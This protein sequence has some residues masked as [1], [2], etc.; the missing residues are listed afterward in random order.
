MPPPKNF[1]VLIAGGGIGGLTLAIILGAA[2]IDYLILE[3]SSRLQSTGSTIGLNACCLRLLEQ[4]GLL[5]QIMA[6]SKPLG[7]LHLRHEDLSKV[8]HLDFRFGEDHYGYYGHVMCRPDLYE[9][10]KNEVPEEKVLLRK[11]VIDVIEF[12]DDDEEATTISQAS[13]PSREKSVSLKKSQKNGGARRRLHRRSRSNS[14]SST[15]SSTSSNSSSNSNGVGGGGVLVRCKDGSVYRGDILVGADG[16]YSSVRE[17][18]YDRLQRQRKLPAC[19]SEPLNLSY[20]CVLGISKEYDTK[21]I[22]ILGDRFS[23]FELINCPDGR[24]IWLGPLPNNRIAW[25]YGRNL[26]EKDKDDRDQKDKYWN[27]TSPLAQ[28]LQRRVEGVSTVYGVKLGDIIGSTPTEKISSVLLEDKTFQTWHTRRVVLLGDAC[29]KML[30]FAGLGAVH[31]MLDGACLVNLIHGMTSHRSQDFEIA[32]Q[33]Y[34]A[35]RLRAATSAVIGSKGF[36]RFLSASSMLGR[37]FRKV[38]LNMPN[39]VTRHVIDFIMRDRPQLSFLPK[40]PDRGSAKAWWS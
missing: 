29:H 26:T 40:I 14:S 15:S 35:Q 8:G 7:G 1:R 20:I 9:I 24:L 11:Q 38:A 18:M 2:K 16:A 28:D 13:R 12:D 33:T 6:I 25:C 5:P 32:F 3:R 21:E 37:V 31:A 10:L 39:W 27:Y 36:G 19:D 34:Q 22:P 17:C 23:D 30:P 4:L